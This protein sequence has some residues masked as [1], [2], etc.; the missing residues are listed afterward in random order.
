L[1]FAR[2]LVVGVINVTPD[3][4][5]DG[6]ALSSIS[7]AVDFALGLVG[8]G[9]DVLD[10]G[11]E[12]TRPRG[13]RTVGAEEEIARVVPLIA[14]LAA[15]TEIPLS[16]DTT[17]SVVAAA[18]L[19]AGATI[20]N[21]ISGGLFDPAIIDE[22]ARRD[23]GYVLGHVRG[24]TLAEVH[25]AEEA[26]PTFDD[27]AGELAERLFALPVNLR[28]RTVVDPGIGFGKRRPQNLELLA[29][30]GELGARLGRPVM[31]G[32]SRKRFLGELFA[33]GRDVAQRDD[34]TVGAC[35]AAVAAGAD[36]VRV[37]DVRRVADALVAFAAV[38]GVT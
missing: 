32:P 25:A 36:L 6:G 13:A 30:A 18:A 3:S 27:V 16:V 31:V 5:S 26:P 1:T 17:K 19:D 9:A 11:G 34:A 2:P 22:T 35:L 37:H 38:R 20:V 21:D 15:R 29:R 28:Q 4:F 12:S 33:G 23:A 24:R 14:A 8:A 7:S 10:I